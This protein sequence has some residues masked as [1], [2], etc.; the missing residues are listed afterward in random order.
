[1]A[2]ATERGHAVC[3]SRK[4]TAA[5]V[6]QSLFGPISHGGSR[7]PFPST[8][9]GQTEQQEQGG[10]TRS[11]GGREQSKQKAE[12]WAGGVVHSYH[13][14]HRGPRAG[15]QR[16]RQ[17]CAAQPAVRHAWRDKDLPDPATVIKPS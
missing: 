17:R 7:A 10:E 6:L 11:S 3:P 12:E 14:H 2:P 15:G 4:R 16:G 8:E 9:R 13:H 5:E 1:M